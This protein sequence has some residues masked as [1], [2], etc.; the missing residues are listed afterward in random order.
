MAICFVPGVNFGIFVTLIHLSLSYH[1]VQQNNGS[2]VSSLNKPA[3]S[4]IR[5]INEINYL[6]RVDRAMYSL[7]VVMR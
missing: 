4:F 3:I 2:L 6:I 5:L 1:T 7:S